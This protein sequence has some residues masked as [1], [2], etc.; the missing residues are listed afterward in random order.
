[1]IA[2]KEPELGDM[3]DGAVE[4][5]ERSSSRSVFR[6]E[7]SRRSLLKAGLLASS[8]TVMIAGK[9]RGSSN[10]LTQL[11]LSEAADLVRRK[12]VSPVELTQACLARIYQLNP[13]LNAFITVTD[14]GALNQA[15]QAEGEIQRGHYRGPLHGIPIALKDLIDTAGV[16]TT[17]ASGVFAD[18]IP[19]TDADLVRRLNCAGA[20]FL[21]KQNMHEFAFGATS[22]VSYFGAV[23]N[24]WNIDY[25]AG[26][27]SGG[28]AAAVA[29]GLCYAAIGTDTGG[30]IRVPAAFCNVVG[31]QPT[32]GRVSTRG[33]IP[34]SW[35]LDHVG[36]IT[37]S[38]RDSALILRT[39]AGYDSEDLAS[40]DQPVG[41]YERDLKRDLTSLRLGIPDAIYYQT[42]EP[43]IENAMNK[44]LSVLNQLTAG[45]RAVDLGEPADFPYTVTNLVERYAFHQPYVE[46]VPELYQPETRQG[47]L[48]GADIPATDYVRERRE[49][50]RLRRTID[51]RF[52]GIDLLI[53]PTTPISPPTIEDA[54]KN[55]PGAVILRNTR[56]FNSYGVPSI[57]IPCGFT[58]SGLPIGLMISGPHWSEG[59]VLSL[60]HAF[61]QATEW[62]SYFPQL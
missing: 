45:V 9:S 43:Q 20:I 30:S 22:I 29:A 12:A 55:P 7:I 19:K 14:E 4:G 13:V 27:S 58:Q 17:A 54:R 23:H 52:T 18:R 1:M 16:R 21:G 53:T 59:R 50:D 15:R 26:G 31:L 25:I 35:T 33:V 62:H 36:P 48:R 60:A 56:R 42:L 34:L 61:E 46:S 41:D 38:A 47:I 57:S 37:R 5:Q 51:D 3:L 32:Y 10:A 49:I 24:P 6:D 44:A 40:V 2:S 39:I 11:T 28:T 8:G